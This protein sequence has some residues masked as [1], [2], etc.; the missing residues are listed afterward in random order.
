MLNFIRRHQA[1]VHSVLLMVLGMVA[2]WPSVSFDFVNWD[3]PVY[4]QNNPLIRDWSVENL[5]AVSTEVIAKNYA[6]LTTLSFMVDYSLWELNPCGYHATNVILHLVNGVLV[7]VLI[8]QLSGSRF[9]GFFTAALFLVHPVQIESVA[10]ISSRKGLLCSLFMLWACI[11]RLQLFA[12]PRDDARYFALLALAL[13]CKAHA[14]VLP[15]IVLLYDVL[16]RRDKLSTAI[17]RQFIAGLM[18]LALLLITMGAQNSM[19]GGVR[20]HM[21]LSLLQIVAVDVT[22][23]WK[24]LWMLLVPANLCVM[25]DP[26]VSGIWKQVAAG[27]V[28]LVLIGII[29]WRARKTQPLWLLGCLSIFLLLFPMLNFFRITTLMNDRYLYLPCIILFA[30]AAAAIRSLLNISSESVDGL[31]SSVAAMVRCS[32]AATAVV[33]CLVM[34]SRYLPVWTNSQSLWAHASQVSPKMPIVRIKSALTAHGSG[35]VRE[36]IRQLKI[37]LLETQPD[38]LDRERMH[39]FIA[40]WTESLA[41]ASPASRN[42]DQRKGA[43]DSSA[44][45]AVPTEALNT[46]VPNTEATSTASPELPDAA[47]LPQPFL[48]AVK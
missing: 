10:W 46:E 20:T 47:E 15:A 37:A 4:V 19:I 2:F 38:E 17:P 6:P 27:S 13:L 32:L 26:P 18:S 34:T 42:R 21:S 30:F 29:V 43:L 31:L 39:G 41:A 14:I 11:L 23:L 48:S 22:I 7:Y 3:D 8:T 24:Y 9:V 33:A 5:K 12:Q 35:L 1:A 40:E 36:G 44:G 25:Y 16:V 28:G 45:D